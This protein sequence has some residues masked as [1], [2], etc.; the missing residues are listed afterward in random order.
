MHK[1]RWFDACW[2]AICIAASS[3]WCLTAARQ[4]SATFDEPLYLERGLESWRTGSHAGLMKLGTMPLP[5]DCATLPLYVYERWAGGEIDP[6]RE[7]DRVLPWAR[8]AALVFWWLL[9]VYGWLA[10]RS[11]AGP[12]GGRLAAAWLACEPNLLAHAT[13]A[14]TDVAVSACTLA[15]VYHFYTAREKTW[16]RR[17]ALPGVWFGAAVLAKASGLVFG[18]LCLLAIEAERWWTE[19][20]SVV[21]SRARP[22]ELQIANC[23]L[24][25]ANSVAERAGIGKC[26]VGGSLR[27]LVQIGLIG[28]AVTFVYCG[29]DWRAE[30]SFVAWAHSLPEGQTHDVMVWMSERLTIFSNAGEGLVRQV[31]HNMRGHH[32]SYLLGHVYDQSLWYYFP[33]AL[34][35]KLV[36]PLLIAPLALLFD[37]IVKRLFASRLGQ[38]NLRTPAD[39][40]GGGPALARASLSHPTNW[41]LV[42]ALVLFAFSL[43]CRVQIGIRLVLPLVAFLV[44]GLAG[45]LAIAIRRSRQDVR[46]VWMA[47]ATAAVLWTGFSAWRVWPEG[48]CYA[49]ELW[50][51]PA[52]GYLCLSDSNYDWGQ[53]LKELAV[54]REQHGLKHLDVWYFGADPAVNAEP[55]RQLPLHLLPIGQPFPLPMWIQG[56]YLAVSTTLLYGTSTEMP[57][58]RAAVEFLRTREPVARTSTFLIYDV[59]TNV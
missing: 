45:S 27:D 22:N 14:T 56:R 25:I 12:W 42:A 58:H 44:V 37:F 28:M 7:L 8:A 36:L 33:V 4:L 51:G 2:L 52:D 29:C 18:P 3:A 26:S 16:W 21:K 39:H 20:R 24:Q 55:F 23:K 48:L 32:G 43:N 5:I 35:I 11:I 15:L 41:A 38:A 1:S 34:T 53:G 9:L 40:A 10:G 49:N 54:W 17:V 13:L 6:A 47:F 31:K 59:G 50:G 30:P 19:R 46:P 57:T